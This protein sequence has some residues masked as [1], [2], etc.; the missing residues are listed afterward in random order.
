MSSRIVNTDDVFDSKGTDPLIDIYTPTL[1]HS[2][3]ASIASV[4]LRIGNE[5]WEF[6][7]E[8]LVF[9]GSDNEPADHHDPEVGTLLAVG[10]ALESAGLKLQKRGHGLVRLHDHNRSIRPEQLKRS[11]K[12]HQL[13]ARRAQT[14]ARKASS[15]KVSSG[16]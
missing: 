13:K 3:R 6:T 1:L 10:R 4:I 12:F 8:S 7:G 14:K 5:W 16:K 11:K 9:P 2:G 15:R